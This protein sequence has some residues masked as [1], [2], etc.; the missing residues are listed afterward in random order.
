MFWNPQ[1]MSEVRRTSSLDIFAKF[2]EENPKNI[3]RK[4]PPPPPANLN[5]LLVTKGIL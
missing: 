3:C 4:N 1:N 5:V 2:F